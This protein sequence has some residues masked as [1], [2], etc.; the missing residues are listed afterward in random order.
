[1]PAKIKLNFVT[2]LPHAMGPQQNGRRYI[3]A[4]T[5]IEYLYSFDSIFLDV[6][7]I[8]KLHKFVEEIRFYI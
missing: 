4:T 5:F 2:S 6:N 1:M 8:D 3:T 7:W